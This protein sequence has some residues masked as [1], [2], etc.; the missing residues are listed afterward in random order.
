MAEGVI[1]RL[2]RNYGFVGP[3]DGQTRHFF[4]ASNLANVDFSKLQEG[5]RVSYDLVPSKKNPKFQDA[6]NVRLLEAARAVFPPYRFSPINIDLAVT[7]NPVWHDGSGG[8]DLFSGVLLCSL[9]ALTPLLPGN[10]RY[11]AKDTCGAKVEVV[12]EQQI[13]KI[14]GQEQATQV[15][16]S[17]AVLPAEWCLPPVHPDKQI[18]EPLRLKDGEVVIPGSTL[19]GMI[20]HSLG[21]L[22]SAPMERVKEHHYT[23]RPNLDI[24]NGEV[25]LSSACRPAVIKSIDDH[26]VEILVLPTAKCAVFARSEIEGSLVPGRSFREIPKAAFKIK[27]GKYGRPDETD[28][29]RIETDSNGGKVKFPE[30]HLVVLYRGGCDGRGLLAKEFDA[31]SKTHTL[32][33]IPEPDLNRAVAL[34]IESDVLGA[35]QQ[36]QIVLADPDVGHLSTYSKLTKKKCEEISQEILCNTHPDGLQTNQLVYVDVTLDNGKVTKDSK[37]VSFGHHFR[38]RWAYTSSVRKKN[39]E[40]RKCLAVTDAEKNLEGNSGE[41]D[42]WPAALTGARL[43]FGYVRNDK[44]NEELSIG[45]GVF[46]RLAGRVA[47]N[48][49]V[50]EGVPKFLGDSPGYCVPLKILGQPKPSAWEFYLSQKDEDD[51]PVTYGDLPGDDGGELAGR[52]FYLH[53]PETGID[54]IRATRCDENTKACQVRSDQATLARF[55]CP[56][57]SK[58]KFAVRFSQLRRWE[59]G[60]L[61]A[62]LEPHRLDE[63]GKP[64]QYAHKLGLGRPLG[65]GSVSIEVDVLR[66]HDRQDSEVENIAEEAIEELLGKFAAKQDAFDTLISRW[67][68]LHEYADRGRLDYPH[69]GNNEI[70]GWHTKLRRDYSK[71][72]RE[73]NPQW[74]SIAKHIRPASETPRKLEKH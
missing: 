39:G 34:R 6:V 8:G 14:R 23:Y 71:L 17:R 30:D 20:R 73:N 33:L 29:T 50:S 40:L 62:V 35:Y 19:K 18:A 67:L 63:D 13:E 58:F 16:V 28:R 25:G 51:R 12:E 65:M 74:D 42:A 36:S 69:D 54:D 21:A 47:F 46:E 41:K 22:L 26:A 68:E 27:R 31:K 52:K 61:L 48:H 43:L 5:G 1:K 38:Y 15:R 56:S 64:G 49:A 2:D 70:Y 37:I 60:A 57:G 10:F 55:I 53:Q 66:I 24:H 7:D 45:K 32:A 11:A 72:R 44:P 4:H 59:L 9:E 3:K